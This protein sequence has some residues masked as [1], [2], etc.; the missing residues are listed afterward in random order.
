[1]SSKK[2]NQWDD[3]KNAIVSILVA[4]NSAAPTP[5]LLDCDTGIDDALALMYLCA[6]HRDGVIDLKAVTTTAGNVD[7]TQTAINTLFVMKACGV[8]DVPVVEGESV[9]LEVELVTTPETHG[10]EGLGYLSPP[11]E[12]QELL[13]RRPWIKLWEDV[14]TQDPETLVIV[15][16]PATNLAKYI[17]AHEKPAK[18]ALM[19]GS[20]NYPGNT[21]ATAEWNTWVDPHAAK[22][23]F[24][25][26]MDILVCSLG[27]TEQFTVNPDNVTRYQEILNHNELAGL[28]PEMLRFYFEFHESVGE[29]Y[30]A[31]IHDLLT[32]ML[33]LA[34]V[35]YEYCSVAIDVA[36]ET[37]L[38]RGTTVAD[39]RNKWGRP[40]TAK[41][42]S[43]AEIDAA[44]KE[45][46]AALAVLAR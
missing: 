24:A 38:T 13:D 26:D 10:P 39:Y 27:V 35:E 36:T 23:V 1:M 2:L 43:S 30:L 7:S 20:Y 14:L 40:Q 29:G 42:V 45:F 25:A 22:E 21:T 19:G 41:L 12:L 8:T 28:L 5:V 9:P 6:L 18:V 11:K 4:M 17:R 44:H 34:R 15:T 16:G 32:C 3:E 31:Q 33:A 37:E 46:E